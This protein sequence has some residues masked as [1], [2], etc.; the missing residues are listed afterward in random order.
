MRQARGS[1]VRH[2]DSCVC[3]MSIFQSESCGCDVMFQVKIFDIPFSGCH[4]EL[5]V[6]SID[7]TCTAVPHLYA[8]STGQA[9]GARFLSEQK[10]LPSTIQ[11]STRFMS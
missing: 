7:S 10:S 6:D 11:L 4:D 2:R 9:Y 3:R 5:T 8:S 1:A